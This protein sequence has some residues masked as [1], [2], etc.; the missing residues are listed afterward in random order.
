MSVIPASCQRLVDDAAIFPP[1]NAPLDRALREHREHRNSDYADLIGGFVISELR[2]PE[3]IDLVGDDDPVPVNLVISGGVGA[4]EGAVRWAARSGQVELRA[5][6]FALRDED[7]L[8]HNARRAIT[9]LD[10][11]EDELGDAATYV[12]MPRVDGAPSFGWSA[13]VEELAMREIP[14]KF[15]TGWLDPVS[16]PTPAELAACIDIALDH[17]LPFKCTAG[18]HRAVAG[19]GAH[20]FLNVMAATVASLDRADVE[21][22]L[23]ETDADALVATVR[24]DGERARRWFRSFGCCAVLEPHEELVDLGLVES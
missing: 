18:L 3:L 14:L 9:M 21:A 6:E 17:E 2:L 11:L 5:V 15:R 16:A 8:A 22:T 20:G 13:A 19:D 12:E 24:T 4:I 10:S 7:D 23:R 1:G